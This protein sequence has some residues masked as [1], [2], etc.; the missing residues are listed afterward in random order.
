MISGES[1]YEP[2]RGPSGVFM[3]EKWNFMTE[4]HRNVLIE[5]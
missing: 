2:L 3:N 4:L 1:F 5:N